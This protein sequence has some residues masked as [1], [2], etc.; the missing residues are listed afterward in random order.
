MLIDGKL[1][2]STDKKAKTRMKPRRPCS[3][4]QGNILHIKIMRSEPPRDLRT[5]STTTAHYSRYPLIHSRC[6]QRLLRITGMPRNGNLS[7]IDKRQLIQIVDHPGGAK[8][9]SHQKRKIVFVL[10]NPTVV[11]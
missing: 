5:C 10:P 1:I 11:V 3:G 9:P 7:R 6:R 2:F 4:Q 8:R